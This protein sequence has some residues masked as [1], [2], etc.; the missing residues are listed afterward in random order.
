M[1]MRFFSAQLPALCQ[2][3]AEIRVSQAFIWRKAEGKYLAGCPA[4][5]QPDIAESRDSEPELG[6]QLPSREQELKW[7]SGQSDFL[8][9]G[10]AGLE[11]SANYI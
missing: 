2:A 9:H 7:S 6:Y 4:P 5:S 3:R 10:M 1:V 11:T 8:K